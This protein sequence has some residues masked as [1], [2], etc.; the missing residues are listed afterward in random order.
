MANEPKKQE[1][2]VVEAA[3]SKAVAEGAP[4]QFTPKFMAELIAAVMVTL[5]ET[6]K[7]TKK[8]EA[9]ALYL[10][11]CERIR[12]RTRCADCGQEVGACNGEHVKMIVFPERAEYGEWFEGAYINGIRYLSNNRGHLV[13]VP[14]IAEG[15]IAR[16]IFEFED[17]EQHLRT[18]RKQTQPRHVGFVGPNGTQS[19]VHPQNFNVGFR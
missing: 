12:K 9:D 8:E 6:E 4:S 19:N 3:V 14:K 7:Q 2:K 5:K 16:T 1:E 18:P 17:N 13:T 15:G 11:E 10:A